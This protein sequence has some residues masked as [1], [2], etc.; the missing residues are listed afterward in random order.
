MTAKGE[1]LLIV[2]RPRY[3]EIVKSIE[4]AYVP[5]VSYKGK[6]I[7]FESKRRISAFIRRSLR[8]SG[9]EGVDVSSPDERDYILIRIPMVSGK[10]PAY[11]E[12]TKKLWS[13][14]PS[15]YEKIDAIIKAWYPFIS[16]TGVPIQYG[17]D[18]EL[19]EQKRNIK[20]YRRREEH[21]GNE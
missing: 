4:R 18:E 20:N 2:K 17:S 3:R 13:E 12:E 1:R 11:R 15:L 19:A 10:S 16:E 9:I 5:K 21:I 8:E 7:I 14:R 6:E